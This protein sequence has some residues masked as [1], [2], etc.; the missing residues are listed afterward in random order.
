M[1]FAENKAGRVSQSRYWVMFGIMMVAI[2]LLLIGGVTA[3]LQRSFL[4]GLLMIVAIVPLGIY[5]RVIM[6]RRCRDIGWPAFLPWLFF[7]LQ[8]AA[9]FNL[10]F[11][12]VAGAAARSAIALPSVLALC[13]FVFSIVIGCIA[14]KQAVDY[15]DIFGDG[16]GEVQRSGPGDAAPRQGGPDRFD[17]AIARALEAHRQ[18]ERARGAEQ[19]GGAAQPSGPAP[20]PFARPAASFGRRVV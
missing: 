14:T 6:M 11:S 15:A 20:A 7:G 9:S 8:M 2:V 19:V 4:I 1:A 12:I 17:D 3:V 13:D 5:W 16:P 18:K 10:Q